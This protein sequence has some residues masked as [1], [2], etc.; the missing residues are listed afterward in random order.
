[1]ARDL[2]TTTELQEWLGL[3]RTHLMRLARAGVIPRAGRGQW[4][5][6]Q[7]VVGYISHMKGLV[8]D[9]GMGT[10]AGP[11]RDTDDPDGMDLDAR[12]KYW[13]GV[14]VQQQCREEVQKI[15]DGADSK[16]RALAVGAMGRLRLALAD[17]DLTDDQLGRVNA[18]LDGAAGEVKKPQKGKA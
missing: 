10:G 4:D 14:R 9:S 11:T 1:M 15:L 6:K 12:L 3:S 5:L 18:A 7:C 16:Y 8:K 2:T 17:C 13:Q